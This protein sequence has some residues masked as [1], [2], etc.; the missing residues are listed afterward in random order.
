MCLSPRKAGEER[1]APDLDLGRALSRRLNGRG[2]GGG[3]GKKKQFETTSFMPFFIIVFI[4]MTLIS[5]VR[6]DDL[7]PVVFRLLHLGMEKRKACQ[8]RVLDPCASSLGRIKRGSAHH[9]GSE[10]YVCSLCN[11]TF[12]TQG[13][14]KR[15]RETVHRQSACFSCQVRSQR[16]CRKDYLGKHMKI[17]QSAVLFGDSAACPTDATVDLPPPPLPPSLPPKRHGET[18]VCDLCAKT[19]SSQ[20]ALKRHRQTVHHQSGGFSCRVCDRPSY[21]L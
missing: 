5:C 8:Y 17:H 16:F 3:F 9:C 12:S 14:L 6:L 2:G 7:F 11:Q 20:K 13:S 15:H 19:F 10:M 18:P 1:N 21:Q 4:G